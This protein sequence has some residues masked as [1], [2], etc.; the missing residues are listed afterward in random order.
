[1]QILPRY[2]ILKN[3]QDSTIAITDEN[4]IVTD[5]FLYDTYG[6]LINRTGTSKIIFGYNG[7]DGVVTDKNGLLDGAIIASAVLVFCVINTIASGGTVFVDDLASLVWAAGEWG[8]V[9][10]AK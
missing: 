9:I 3:R 8:K 2:A 10:F 1:M 5:T 6:K 7:K 4:G